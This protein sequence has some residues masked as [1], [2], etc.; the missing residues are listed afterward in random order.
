[1]KSAWRQ[2]VIFKEFKKEV[3][4]RWAFVRAVV[5]LWVVGSGV[6]LILF[7]LVSGLFPTRI[8]HEHFYLFSALMLPAAYVANRLSKKLSGLNEALFSRSGTYFLPAAIDLATAAVIAFIV[9]LKLLFIVAGRVWGKV[10]ESE[11]GLR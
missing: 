6:G 4:S 3:G 11:R 2:G 1:M 9:C 10:L 5:T 8:R 7:I